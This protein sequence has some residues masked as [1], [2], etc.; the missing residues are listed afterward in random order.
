MTRELAQKVVRSRGTGPSFIHRLT[1]LRFALPSGSWTGAI[2]AYVLYLSCAHASRQPAPRTAADR[3]Y[4][5]VKQGVLDRRYEGGTLLTEGEL[6]EAVGVSRTP[7]PRGPAAAG[8]RRAAQ[9]LPEEGRAGP[10]GLRAG[11]RRRRRDPAARRGVHASARPCPAPPRLLERLEEPAGASRR[12][13]AAA[14]DLAAVSPS[15]T[16]A[17]TPR[18]S[19]APATRSSPAS[20]T[21]SA[22]GSCGWASPCCTPT[23]TGSTK[24]AR[25]A[26]RDPGRA[27]GRGRGGGGGRRPPARRLG[28]G[29]WSRG[30]GPMSRDAA[31]AALPGDPPGGRRAVAVWGIGV[32]VYF[33]AVI[34]RTSAWASPAS[35]PPT[36]ST[37]TPPRCPPS[38]YSS[39]WSTRACRYPSA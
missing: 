36:A 5:H 23:P 37:S 2:D 8:D 9:A 30:R 35:T 39:C 11:D 19:A 24:H 18:S 10:A 28:R 16:A 7:G 27:A 26:R 31:S 4:P 33:V 1:A 13:Q 21:S 3:V 38:P 6:A 17:S 29:T 25:R 14:G 15:P 34:F 22:T 20:T 32:A 12:R